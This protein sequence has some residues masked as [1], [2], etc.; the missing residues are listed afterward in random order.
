[1]RQSCLSFLM[2]N[3]QPPSP[4]EPAHLFFVCCF[5]KKRT[6]TNFY[7]RLLLL[8]FFILTSCLPFRRGAEQWFPMMERNIASKVVMVKCETTTRKQKDDDRR[9][10]NVPAYSKKFAE[11]ISLLPWGGQKKR[12]GWCV[13]SLLFLMWMMICWCE[14]VMTHTTT[15]YQ[16]KRTG[17]RIVDRTQQQKWGEGGIEFLL[18]HSWAFV[19]SS[20]PYKLMQCRNLN[21]Y[22]KVQHKQYIGPSHQT[23]GTVWSSRQLRSYSAN[24]YPTVPHKEMATPMTQWNLRTV[25]HTTRSW[26]M[27]P[28]LGKEDIERETSNAKFLEIEIV[29]VIYVS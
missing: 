17:D 16:H 26:A 14:V 6:Q 27:I 13:V 8:L 12:W 4:I 7:M 1:M 25:S 18:R 23:T 19:W 21:S 10:T 3:V 24:L 11:Q 2:A 29:C 22:H 9:V 5:R 28:M 15:T 20:F